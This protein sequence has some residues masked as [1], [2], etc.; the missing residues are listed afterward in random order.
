MLGGMD[1][2]STTPARDD[3]GSDSAASGDRIRALLAD[4]AAGSRFSGVCLVTRGDETLVHEAHGLA[5]RG[6]GVPNT[7]HTRFD[8]ASVTKVFTAAAILQLIE[9]G[10]ITLDTTVMPFIGV[11]GT[12]IADDVT[13]FHCLTH[14]SG[15]ADDADEEAGE[16]YEDLFVDRPNYAIRET[17]DFL[18]QFA[19]KDPV[20]APGRGVRYN[21]CAF[22]LLGL[23]I[24]RATGMSYRD[25]VREHVFA[26][27]GM[28]GADFCAMDGVHQ[29]MAEHYKR[30]DHDGDRVEWR[31][32][33]YSY[34]PIGSPD[35]GATVTALDLERFTRAVTSGRLMG[36]SESQLFQRPHVLVRQ[37]QDDRLM[38]GF[39]FEFRVA[40]DGQVR[41]MH[42]EGANA[43]VSSLLVRY[44][45]NDL[46]VILLANI[47]C[48][49]WGILREIESLLPV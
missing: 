29:D 21:N 10:A 49:V 37:G 22:V 43:G 2:T 48:D 41:R 4:H 19:N 27:A 34:P 6:F 46:T 36:A 38:N 26:R 3:H 32:N 31:K 5:H 33:I 14:T 40:L 12:R 24:E 7:V 20:F 8:I 25:Y 11:S 47:E 23:V 45:P 18:P 35:G 28:T 42:K 9:A 16:V 17:A 44:P 13:V 39:A 15:I 1:D 30:I